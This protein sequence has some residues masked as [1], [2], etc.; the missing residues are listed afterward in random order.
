MRPSFC[1][2]A[3]LLAAATLATGCSGG[4]ATA[5]DRTPAPLPYTVSGTLSGPRLATL[6]ADTR[7]VIVW[8]AD[9]GAG[10]YGYQW[11]SGTV[12]A[13]SGRFSITLA[14]DPPTV[15]TF[16]GANGARL[17]VGF[18]VLVPAGEA[19]VGRIDDAT[20]TERALGAAGQHAVIYTAGS[21]A[22]VVWASRFRAGYNVGRGV[23]ARAGETFDTFEPV[24]PGTVQVIVDALRN[25]R[26]VN[27]S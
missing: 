22:G 24:P 12:D 19:R 15:A 11:G 9:D 23:P 21:P 3:P 27:W 18:V 20:F 7:A 5:P 16:S 25:I 13:A 14:E 10:D 26:V 6:P 17:G 4:E 2:L 1:R 8:A